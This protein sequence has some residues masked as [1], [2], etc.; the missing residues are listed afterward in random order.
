MAQ[1]SQDSSLNLLGSL[2]TEYSFVVNCIS[3]VCL[4]LGLMFLVPITILIILDLFLW[5]W[6]MFRTPTDS[7]DSKIPDPLTADPEP[8]ARATGLDSSTLRL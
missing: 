7:C 5:I 4:G 3:L 8:T 1:S 2:M 6:R